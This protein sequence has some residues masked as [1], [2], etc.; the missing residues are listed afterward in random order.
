MLKHYT[1]RGAEAK[2]A[3]TKEFLYTPAVRPVKIK[4]RRFVWNISD[5][6]RSRVSVFSPY[7]HL[8]NNFLSNI[9]ILFDFNIKVRAKEEAI[10]KVYRNYY[11]NLF[12]HFLLDLLVIK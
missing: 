1:E 4:V 5:D 10:F 12:E 8:N 2:L 3:T 7:I 6:Y 11:A 9:L